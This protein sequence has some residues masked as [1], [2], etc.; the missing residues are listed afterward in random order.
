MP[1]RLNK[2]DKDYNKSVADITDRVRYLIE[3]SR[4]PQGKFAQRISMD[5]ANLSKVLSGSLKMSDTF[6]NRLVVELGISK[7]WLLTG[8]GVPFDKAPEKDI[9]RFINPDI[10]YEPSRVKGTPIYDID[11]T[12]GFSE[13]SREL[14]RE[15]IIGYLDFPKLDPKCVVVRV[16]GD[17]MT[18]V[19]PDGSMVA[20]RQ[21]STTGIISWG[22]I[23]T[24]VTEDYRLVKYVRK[25]ADSD[26]ITLHSANPDYD[27]IEMSKGEIISLYI[28]DAVLSY[29]LM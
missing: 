29:K 28:V 4:L 10:I 11:V 1:Q 26:K 24:I 19:I 8:E 18:P 22:Q 7:H 12:A 13:L 25:N 23:Y 27:D 14:T 2:N 15:N 6:L 5:P 16:S 9:E 3:L 20:I 17:S 21:V